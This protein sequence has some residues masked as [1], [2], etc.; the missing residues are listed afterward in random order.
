MKQNLVAFISGLLFAVG[1]GVSGMTQPAK[2]I[3]FLDFA[4]RWDPS[5]VLVLGAGVAVHFIAYRLLR[6]ER[7]VFAEGFSIPTRTDIDARL[8]IGSAI[9]GVGWGLAGYCPGPAISLIGTGALEPLA[10]V[11]AMM[12][13]M[14]LH[15]LSTR[16]ARAAA[17]GAARS[18]PA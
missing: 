18:T 16:P 15:H 11:A 2:V 1:L 9:F 8:V 6:G 4:G 12:V 3:G 13:G 17:A 14:V 10:F 7:A 5:L